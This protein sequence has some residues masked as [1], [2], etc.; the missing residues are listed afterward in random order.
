M[1]EKQLHIGIIACLAP[2]RRAEQTQVLDAEPLQL[3][4][5]CPES[6]N[7]GFAVDQQTTTRA[8]RFSE[9]HAPATATP[10]PSADDDR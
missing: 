9:R 1:I 2:S 4:L 10:K 6:G 8:A 3:S 7:G 5:V